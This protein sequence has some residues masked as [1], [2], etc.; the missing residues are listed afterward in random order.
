MNEPF[1]RAWSLLKAPPKPDFPYFGDAKDYHLV[2]SWNEKGDRLSVAAVQDT[3][4]YSEPD[5]YEAYV[6]YG[7]ASFTPTDEGTLIPVTA[8][9]QEGYRRWGI[10]TE[11]YDY[12]EEITG[13]PVVNQNPWQSADAK[14]FWET[15]DLENWAESYIGDEGDGE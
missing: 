14:A 7:L 3:S 9:V 6:Q 15:R 11:L 5:D 8:G 2:H 13:M 1:D 10:M 12:A 4:M